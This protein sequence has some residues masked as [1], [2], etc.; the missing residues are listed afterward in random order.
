VTYAPT[1]THSPESRPP[2]PPGSYAHRD[3][4]PMKQ[5]NLMSNSGMSAKYAGP[6][7]R[8]HVRRKTADLAPTT[9]SQRVDRVAHPI[10]S[11]R[12]PASP[13]RKEASSHPPSMHLLG[14]CATQWMKANAHPQPTAFHPR[15]C[16]FSHRECEAYGNNP[17]AT[18]ATFEG[19]RPHPA[20]ESAV[21]WRR[22]YRS[23]RLITW[24]DR[25]EYI[26]YD[27]GR[28]H[29]HRFTMNSDF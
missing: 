6:K 21:A 24:N 17:G 3:N 23:I 29:T 14:R 9:I 27:K 8:D 20:A 19:C 5:I 4:E 26:G 10:S 16:H 13:A 18:V 22:A 7:C 28:Y 25:P 11:K 12:Y 15:R 1:C 2:G